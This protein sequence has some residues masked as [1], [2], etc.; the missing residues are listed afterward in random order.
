VGEKNK[1]QGRN[2]YNKNGERVE[3]ICLR[4]EGTEEQRRQKR[5]ILITLRGFILEINLYRK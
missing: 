2:G 5:G 1:E 4:K 3:Q